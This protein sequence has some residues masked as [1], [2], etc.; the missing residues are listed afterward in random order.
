[1]IETTAAVTARA[2]IAALDLTNLNDDCTEGD[3]ATLCA[4]AVTAHGKVAA[5][6]IWPRFVGF[7]RRHVASGVRIATVVNFP[8]G[9][10]KPDATWNQTVATVVEGADEIDMVIDYRRLASEPGYVERQVRRVKDA[11]ASVTLKA[12]LETG[13][14]PEAGLVERACQEALTGGADFLKT[15]T[16][17][18]RISA[19]PEAARI[20]LDAIAAKGGTTGF[21]PSGGIKTYEDA[22]AYRDLAEGICGPGWTTQQRF[23]IGA[24][25]VLTDLLAVAG[26]AP[27][28]AAKGGY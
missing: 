19:T 1:M 13:E 25:S 28:G 7:A 5:I 26:G 9:A 27:R 20:M 22:K 2:L 17:K 24:S 16:G 10:D 8:H 21:K 23:R 6:C 18:T 4:N 15:S 14:I 11:A 12:I 3:V